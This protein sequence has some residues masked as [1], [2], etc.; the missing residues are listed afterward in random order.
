MADGRFGVF[1]LKFLHVN[2]AAAAAKI[3]GF[4]AAIDGARHVAAA[5]FADDRHR[6]IG[7]D[8]AA[9]GGG[10]KIEGGTFRDAHRHPAAGSL[11]LYLVQLGRREACGDRA[12]GSG[13]VDLPRNVF[14]RDSTAARLHAR[15]AVKILNCDRATG[16][17]ALEGAT[18]TVDVNAAA[19]GV[20]LDRALAILDP[21]AATGSVA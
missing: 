11:Q 18:A 6:Q 8:I 15:G 19:T 9:R 12:A 2:A 10:I 3:E 4:A 17:V 21:D 5:D 14:K 1:S 13:A 7:A 20:D 16:G